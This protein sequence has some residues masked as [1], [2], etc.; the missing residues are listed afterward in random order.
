MVSTVDKPAESVV[1]WEKNTM[2]W[3]ISSYACV[4][5]KDQVNPLQLVQYETFQFPR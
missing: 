5:K 3:L 2:S 1:L 4:A